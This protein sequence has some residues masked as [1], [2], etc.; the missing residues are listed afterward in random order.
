MTKLIGD[1]ALVLLS[2]DPSPAVPLLQLSSPSFSSLNPRGLPEVPPAFIGPSAAPSLLAES[3][4]PPYVLRETLGASSIPLPS[5]EGPSCGQQ[6]I[7][8][9][10][11]SVGADRMPPLRQGF[12]NCPACQNPLGTFKKKKKTHLNAQASPQLIIQSK[13]FVLFGLQ[14]SRL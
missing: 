13:L 11:Q 9:G 10:F 4:Q 7:P 2:N 8:S 12:V 1:R 14:A 5:V 6:D 3:P